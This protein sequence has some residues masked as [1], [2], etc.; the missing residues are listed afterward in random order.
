MQKT[1]ETTEKKLFTVEEYHHMF[2][3]GVFGEGA[4]VELVDGEVYE[5]AAVGSRHAACVDRLNRLFNSRADD[6]IIVRVQNPVELSDL[7]EPEPDI[8]LL[9]FREDFYAGG[10]PKP[11]DILLAVEVSDTTLRH[12]TNVKLPA[13]ARAGIPEV[14]IVDLNANTIH[15]HT[16]PKDGE[17]QRAAR[18]RRG[19]SFESESLSGASV[20]ANDIL[21]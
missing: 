5:M 8:A 10:H 4:R 14:W 2:E 15:I 9:K 3:A 21:G 7:S 18:A 19:E 12:D 13:Y 20:A 1:R 11:D 6:E 17:Y 16:G